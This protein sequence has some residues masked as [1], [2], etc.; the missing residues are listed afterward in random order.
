MK[1]RSVQFN[2]RRKDFTIVADGR[3]LLFPFNRCVPPPSAQNPVRQAYVDAELGAEGF[4]YVLANGREG[5]VHVD[6]VLE[7]NRDPQYM[8]E[9]FVYNLTVQVK[10][11]LE[12]QGVSKR[13]IMR[14]LQTSPA[15]L[16]RLLDEQRTAKSLPQLFAILQTL[17]C[18]ID[19]V[20]K[21]R[22][23]RNVIPLAQPA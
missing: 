10:K 8:Q 20:L 14:R 5:T 23:Q 3:S 16:Y 6:H 4:T 7:Y 9:L 19:L 1:V 2:N 12:E 13:E 18:E 17:D 15:Q 22:G 21:H 11:L